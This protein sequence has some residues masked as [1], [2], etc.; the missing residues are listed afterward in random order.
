MQSH[1][2]KNIEEIRVLKK[3]PFLSTCPRKNKGEMM[4]VDCGACR[5]VACKKRSN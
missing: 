4:S 5:L 1:K 3:A 2:F